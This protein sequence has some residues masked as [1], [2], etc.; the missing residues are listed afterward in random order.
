MIGTLVG[1]VNMLNGMDMDAGASSN[2]GPAMATALI[3]TFMD[4]CWHIYSFLR[5]PK[6]TRAE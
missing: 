1:L 6:T 2:I 5:S 4:V 3:T